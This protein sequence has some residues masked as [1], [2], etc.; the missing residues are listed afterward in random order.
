[1][2]LLKAFYTSVFI[3]LLLLPITTLA[4]G[5]GI[6][7]TTST[8]IPGV[9]HDYIVSLNEIV[10][11]A[12]GAL[13]I[14]I[15]QPTPQERGQNWPTYAFL[16]DSNLQFSLLPGWFTQQNGNGNITILESLTYTVL[17]HAAPGH[18]MFTSTSLSEC[19]QTS[20]YGCTN[21]T[22]MSY[23]GF[24]F[25]DPEGGQHGLGITTGVPGTH[26]TS[27]DC[28]VFNVGD[29]LQGGDEQYKA[30][31]LARSS[32]VTIVDS[33]GNNPTV[34][35]T[36]GNY[37]NT[38]GRTQPLPNPYTVQTQTVNFS[39]TFNLIE[40][41]QDPGCRVSS[42]T[43]VPPQV[44]GPLSFTS[45]QSVTLSNGQQYKFQYDPTL[46]LLDKITY[47][48]GATVTYTWG[49]IPDAEGVQ[50][51]SLTGATQGGVCSVQH[52]WFA[53][54][55]RVVSYNGVNNAEEQDFTY[56]TVWPNSNSYHWT[57]KTTTVTT[58]DLVRGTSF[59]TKYTYSPMLPPPESP[60][61]WEDLGYMPVENT[62]TYYD[63]T[64]AVLKTVTK[65]WY[66]IS[67]L[68][69]QC[70]TLPN[71]Q[72]SGSFYQ[73]Q[74]YSSFGTLLSGAAGFTTLPTD[75]AEYDYGTV[76]TACTRPSTL[77][78]RETKTTY[79][80]FGNTP[81]FPGY[82][83]LLDRPS[84]VQVYGLSSNGLSQLLLQET[85]YQYD[86][87]APSNVSPTPYGHDE[88]NYG[89]G[90]NVPRGNPT[91]VTK[92]CFAVATG[93]NCPNP[94]TTTY[95]YDTT[96][97]L[98][99]VK[100]P[101]SNTT[102]YTYTDNYTSDDGS[103][104]ANTNA[105]VTTITRPPTNGVQHITKFQYG[106]EDG[107]LRSKTDEN[108]LVTTF[109]YWTDG[110]S[111]SSFDPFVRFTGSV[112]PDG[113]QTTIIYN[114]SSLTVT[115]SKQINSSET[116]G[117]VALYDGFGHTKQTQLTSDP[118]GTVF[119]DTAYDGLGNV[120]S[121][122]NPYRSGSDITTSSGTTYYF[123]DA[124]GRKCLEVPPD[125]TL[126]SGGA[127]PSSQPANDLFT[128][129]VNNTTMVSDQ[130]GRSRESVTDAL[131]HLTQVVEDPGTSPHLN[132]E[133]N[134]TND[135]LGNLTS[136]VQNG[137]HQRNFTYDSLSRLL[138]AANPESG[139][140]TYTYD[141]NGNVQT[142]QDARGITTTYTYDALNRELTRTY[143]N[144]D[145][146]VTTAYDQ[147]NCLGL[148]TCQNIGQRTSMTD[149]AGS[150]NWAYDVPG[151]MHRDQRTSNSITKTTT[152]SLDYAGNVTSV[153]YPTSRVVNYT[154]DS[155]DRP[156]TAADGSNGITYATGFK[157]SPGGTCAANVA[158][159]TP[160]GTFYALSI[161]QT[162]SFSG[163][164]LTHIY[165]S[166]LQPQEF[167]ASSTGGNAID[168]SYSYADPLNGNHNAGHVFNLTNNLDPT[169]S[170][171]FTYDQLNR[172]TSALTT[173][174]YSTSP[175][176]CWGETYNVD[177]WG[178]L[179]SIAA[180]T[181]SAYNGCSE[182]SG[183]STQADGNNHLNGF[184]YDASGNST[185]D[186]VYSYNWNAESQ[187]KSAGGVNYLYDGDGRR[188]EKV[189]SKLYWYGSGDQILAETNASG[190]ALNEYVF[191]GGKRI[192]MLPAGGNP[193]YYVEDL[194]GTSRVMTTNAGVKCYDADF[195]PYGIERP[196]Y[197]NTC[198]GNNYKFEGKER[199]TETGNDDFGA[200]YYSN[201]FGRWL[202]ADWSA[203]PAPVPYANF[204]NPQTLNLYGMV[205]DDPES[206]ADLDGHCCDD[207][208]FNQAFQLSLDV[209][210]SAV[211]EGDV[212]AGVL[213]GLYNAVASFADANLRATD[214]GTGPYAANLPLAQ[215]SNTNQSAAMAATTIVIAV[216]PI[217]DAVAPEATVTRYMGEG[218]AATAARAHEIPN[219]NRSGEPKDIHF[220]TEKPM[221][222]ATAAKQRYELS[223]TPTHRATVP[224]DRVTNVQ[225]APSGPTTSGGGSQAVTPDP[226][227]VKPSEI[228]KLPKP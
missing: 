113:G 21:Y 151:L 19:I 205:S 171:T 40:N 130:T 193:L 217:A 123:Y 198:P 173:S 13:S 201:R 180:T 142:K 16:Y 67:L 78:L 216:A 20:Q 164:N 72:T 44:G 177:A 66:D 225:P 126:P 88:A 133:T 141:P 139:T 206:F 45:A 28:N 102:T 128:V 56:S 83:S 6:G 29:Y 84:A 195:Y 168:I 26:N 156:S 170:Q 52:D 68:A 222:S 150:E 127:C 189:G 14:R 90:S 220:T 97:Q 51:K 137:S 55:K 38:T 71:G 27:D 37:R 9:P 119:T 75:I 12:N 61:Y 120:Y 39:H 1:M 87:T 145:P 98:L 89:Y 49:V 124:L 80:S 63:T 79:Q 17:P 117:T 4:Q 212:G 202:S 2:A 176:H 32:S 95:T 35:D 227:P 48:T 146:T 159:Y 174:T 104:T 211:G 153:I 24:T 181:N 185:S 218:E 136:I 219:T 144:G 42:I 140:I 106:F 8:P 59:T 81:L 60:E 208:S 179:Q 143:S 91:T 43:P 10:N 69:A 58:K 215:P 122:S 76:S 199:D 31:L 169:R 184:G 161:G 109:C 34:E 192:A 157:T 33:H 187:L 65:T 118:Q 223:E 228:R 204:T 158:C 163:V 165:N 162:S 50:Y 86:A 5:G 191:F 129:Y 3:G 115:T 203:V 82:P 94:V 112:A 116:L 190:T 107:K 103:P 54:T 23:S 182:E 111:G 105:Y 226:I 99:S 15:A 92:K 100:D 186:T 149:A 224:A 152:Y 25:A 207:D 74:P 134:Y 131:G 73:Y 7:N 148:S 172:I 138:T 64:G 18:I 183:F 96:G 93:Q 147:S 209:A 108:N 57:S 178:N 155:A 188:V 121:V 30:T 210:S 214:F 194:L 167:K 166:R 197:T 200:R 77:P 62:I 101:N 70:E 160:Q 125:G 110:C 36:N 196:A 132:Y 47:P 213:K 11:P 135:A 114:D 22:C 154:Y 41:S 221:D 53:I 46:G 85:D 175:S